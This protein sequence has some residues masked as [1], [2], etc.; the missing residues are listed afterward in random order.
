[1]IF[2]YV[3]LIGMQYIHMPFQKLRYDFVVQCMEVTKNQK[4]LVILTSCE[5]S[6]YFA[7]D[8]VSRI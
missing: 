8:F 5:E 3:L 1:M 2:K 4:L 6:T 7:L